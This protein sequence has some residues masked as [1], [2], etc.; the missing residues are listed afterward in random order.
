MAQKV[1]LSPQ[2]VV[3]YTIDVDLIV[4]V[5]CGTFAYCVYTNKGGGKTLIHTVSG[6]CSIDI[7]LTQSNRAQIENGYISALINTISQPLNPANA[8]SNVIDSYTQQHHTNQF[9]G[10]SS[11]TGILQPNQCFI[12]V[13]YPVLSNPSKFAHTKGYM[14]MQD[15]TL[16]SLSGFTKLA[17]NIELK[18]LSFSKSG[19]DKLKTILT[20]GF[21]I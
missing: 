14:C 12:E 8:I 3:G 20:T 10:C 9:G 6:S 2:D 18:N 16:E 13:K 11:M 19:I 17:N 15:F 5:I 4:D 1:T 7:P 21:Y